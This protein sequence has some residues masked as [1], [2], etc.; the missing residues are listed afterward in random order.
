MGNELNLQNPSHYNYYWKILIIIILNININLN[1]RDMDC[2][3][4]GRNEDRYVCRFQTLKE[5]P[6]KCFT[7][8]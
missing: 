8:P 7:Q 5:Q 2:S 3:G 1:T 4:E 6:N